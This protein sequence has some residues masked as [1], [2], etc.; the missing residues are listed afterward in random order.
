L[1]PSHGWAL[2]ALVLIGVAL[3]FVFAQRQSQPPAELAALELVRGDLNDTGSCFSLGSVLVA[4]R[5]DGSASDAGVV[6][7]TRVRDEWTLRVQRGESWRAYTFVKEP[8]RVR[9]VRVAFSDDLPQVGVEKA[10]DELLV[11][12]ENGSVPRVKRCGGD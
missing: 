12:T 4:N 9:P 10:V 2:F 8:G 11:A 6:W 7:T 3:W 1:R 5:L